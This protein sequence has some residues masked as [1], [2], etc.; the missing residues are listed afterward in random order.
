MKKEMYSDFIYITEELMGKDYG[1]NSS[2]RF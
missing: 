1:Y 2:N